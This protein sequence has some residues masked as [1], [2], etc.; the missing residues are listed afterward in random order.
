MADSDRRRRYATWL[1]IVLVIGT[2]AN[3]V[4]EPSLPQGGRAVVVKADGSLHHLVHSGQRSIAQ[5]YGLY[6]DLRSVD[7]G[8]LVSFRRSGVNQKLLGAFGGMEMRVVDYEPAGHSLPPL[9]EPTGEFDTEDRRRVSYWLVVGIP[10]DTYWL[11]EHE[12][13]LVVVAESVAPLPEAAR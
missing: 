3:F 11:A 13:G 5:R 8:A 2:L 6:F 10:G 7:G 1:P 9:G 4:A 12:G